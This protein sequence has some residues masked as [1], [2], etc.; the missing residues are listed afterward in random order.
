M[1]DAPTPKP[2]FP[3]RTVRKIERRKLLEYWWVLPVGATL[4]AFGYMIDY[5]KHVTL[6]KRE[7]GAPKYVSKPPRRVAAIA[8]F[9]EPFSMRDFSFAGTS[10]VLVRLERPTAYSLTSSG[11]HFVAFSRVCT[12]LGCLVN[13]LPNPDAVALTYNYRPDHPVLGCP[14]HFSVFDP[15]R[16]GRSVI[17]RALYPLPRVR[18]EARGDELFATGIEPPPS[19]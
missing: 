1:S 18:L 10:C 19:A 6:D 16:E 5:A 8:D 7:A 13:H 3:K 17:G 15:A 9:P 14:C 11:A 2:S 12:H 4:G